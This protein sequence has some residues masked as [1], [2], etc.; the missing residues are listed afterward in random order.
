MNGGGIDQMAKRSICVVEDEARKC[1]GFESV[2]SASGEMSLNRSGCKSVVS[3][4]PDILL[5]CITVDEARHRVPVDGNL[6]TTR[7]LDVH[8]L[9][10]RRK[11]GEKGKLFETVCGIG[12]RMREESP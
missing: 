9:G 5:P 10:L 6:V 1:E 12:Y 8:I 3:V 4:I 11:H 2:G 7:A